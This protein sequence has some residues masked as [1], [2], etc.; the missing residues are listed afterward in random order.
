MPQ[1]I[2]SSGRGYFPLPTPVLPC[3]LTHPHSLPACFSQEMASS[4]REALFSHRG[5]RRLPVN[6]CSGLLQGLGLAGCLPLTSQETLCLSCCCSAEVSCPPGS[7]SGAVLALRALDYRP[8]ESQSSSWLWLQPDFLV[9][10]SA[11]KCLGRGLQK[12]KPK[13]SFHCEGGQSQTD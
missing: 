2:T 3:L 8:V 10:Y 6:S 5:V 12:N 7:L 11:W 4:R 1:I 13:S 9:P